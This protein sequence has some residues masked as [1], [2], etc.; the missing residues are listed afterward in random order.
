MYCF[1]LQLELFRSEQPLTPLVLIFRNHARPHPK[2]RPR[3]ADMEARIVTLEAELTEA[4]RVKQELEESRCWSRKRALS[5]PLLSTS[6]TLCA[7]YGEYRPHSAT[8]TL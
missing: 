6:T 7:L 1:Q 5:K 3:A 2:P 8:C 4:I